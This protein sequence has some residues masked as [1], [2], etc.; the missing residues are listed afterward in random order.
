MAVTFP[1][2]TREW[3]NRQTRTVQVRVLERVWGFNSPLA[4]R[5]RRLPSHRNVRGSLLNSPVVTLVDLTVGQADQI[6][7]SV[8][9]LDTKV[10]IPLGMKI[11]RTPL[12]S[13]S[14]TP[15]PRLIWS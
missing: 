7:Y 2:I 15:Q 3:R 5:T 11:M 12:F 13:S 10:D 6:G 8:L 1:S 9:L 14:I 4:H